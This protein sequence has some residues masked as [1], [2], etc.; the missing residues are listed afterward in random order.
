M[1]ESAMCYCLVLCRTPFVDLAPGMMPALIQG[2]SVPILSH[3]SS[4]LDWCRFFCIVVRVLIYNLKL[5]LI[6]RGDL[7]VNLGVCCLKVV[8]WWYCVQLCLPCY[9]F[10]CS[11]GMPPSRS[12]LQILCSSLP[13]ACMPHKIQPTIP[14]LH[15]TLCLNKL[16]QVPWETPQLAA[17][18]LCCPRFQRGILARV[19]WG[20]TPDLC[21][22]VE[23]AMEVQGDLSCRKIFEISR[24]STTRQIPH[25]TKAH[26]HT[27]IQILTYRYR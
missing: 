21:R 10:S 1:Y 18:M 7:G 4:F 14:R 11:P 24:C 2:Y 3:L 13:S 19:S 9:L 25:T 16:F 26:I 8:S 23:L 12:Q 20:R 5:Q 15:H 27:Y 17:Q 6:V 22:G